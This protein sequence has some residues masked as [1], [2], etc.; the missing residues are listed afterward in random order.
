MI[1]P[2][3][4]Y[5]HKRITRDVRVD[6]NMWLEFLENFNGIVF[7]LRVSGVLQKLSNY[8]LIVQVQIT[9]AVVYFQEQWAYYQR[10]STWHKPP[11]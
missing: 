2:Y 10:L 3:K 4:P 7:L 9:W 6:M 5:H 8:L 11:F 1:G